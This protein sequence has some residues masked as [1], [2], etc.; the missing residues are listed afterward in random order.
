MPGKA[1]SKFIGPSKEVSKEFIDKSAKNS[2][3]IFNS[4][5][6]KNGKR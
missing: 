3:T 2:K 6:K 4:K 1:N 5:K